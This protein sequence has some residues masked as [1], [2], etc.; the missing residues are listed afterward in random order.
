MNSA[1][2]P[3]QVIEGGD[4]ERGALHC[5]GLSVIEEVIAPIKL[6]LHRHPR[7]F[8]ETEVAG[9][10]IAKTKLRINGPDVVLSHTVWFKIEEED[11][12]VVM[13]WVE[14]SDPGEMDWEYDLV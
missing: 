9:V 12:T 13:L 4:F 5:G 1:G 8:R 14:I 6:G 3:W 2:N 7:G 11:R 10:W